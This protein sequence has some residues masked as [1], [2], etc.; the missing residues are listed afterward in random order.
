M[1]RLV[2]L[3]KI[4]LTLGVSVAAIVLSQPS[5]LAALVLGECLV[6]FATGVL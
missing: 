6:L 3:T 1:N 2:P 5:S 4:I